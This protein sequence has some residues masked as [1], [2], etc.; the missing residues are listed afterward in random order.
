MRTLAVKARKKAA[1]VAKEGAYREQ[2]RHPI[3]ED[4][5]VFSAYWD[6]G[7]TCSPGAISAKLAELAPQIRQVWVV[8]RGDVPLVPAGHR[9]RGAR[10]APLL[11]RDGARQVPGQQRQLP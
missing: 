6:R 4:L 5:A 8:R 7:V 11:E 1:E 3:E 10:L 2:L 9:L